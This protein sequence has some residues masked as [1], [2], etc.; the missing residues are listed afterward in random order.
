MKGENA[1]CPTNIMFV[2]VKFLGYNNCYTMTPNLH[3][4]IQYLA[5]LE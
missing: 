1:I 2:S 4:K 5:C 3:L